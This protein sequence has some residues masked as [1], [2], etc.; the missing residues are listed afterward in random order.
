MKRGRDPGEDQTA[1]PRYD[2][3]RTPL[4]RVL[5]SGVVSVE[6]QQ[7]LTEV[8]QALDPVRLLEQIKSLQQAVLRYAVTFSALGQRTPPAQVEVFSVEHCTTGSLPAL[9]P[10]PDPVL[11]PKI[12][13]QEAS[14]QQEE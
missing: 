9:K 6:K 1:R 4:Q 2:E 8:A 13:A 12:S 3:A 14:E 10:T 7:E 5:L 11:A